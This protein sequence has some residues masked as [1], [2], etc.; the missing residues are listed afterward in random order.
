VVLYYALGG[1]LGHLT[2]GRRVLAAL[3]LS[4]RAALL[5]ASTFARDAR[6]T[7]G[8]PV[9][10]V[11]TRLGR[12]RCAFRRWLIDA[13]RELAPEEVIVDAFPGGILG[14]LCELELPPARYVARRVRWAAYRRRL[15]GS[16]PRYELAHVLEPLEPAHWQA[17]ETCARRV[18]RLDLPVA[19]AGGAPLVERPHTLVVHS[20]PEDEVLALA[21]YAREL[22]PQD[23]LVVVAPSRPAGLP[24]GAVWQDVYPAA[25]HLPFAELVVTAGG[26]NAV[27]DGTPVRERHRVIP[28][29]RPLDDQ[30]ARARAAFEPKLPPWSRGSSKP[31]PGGPSAPP[32]SLPTAS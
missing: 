23:T 10:E 20:G 15:P 5:T 6:V 19:A 3:G 32:S 31:P 9:I 26:F 28:F 22:R 4:D 13:L 29:P 7:G 12:D 30:F 25:P 2:R 18:D 1:G 21:E 16:L 17:V 11:P 27:L 14:E 8:L 24:R